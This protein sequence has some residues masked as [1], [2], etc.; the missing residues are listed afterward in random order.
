M[1][2][3]H[4]VGAAIARAAQ[5]LGPLVPGRLV[6]R[7]EY[8]ESR[9][10]RRRRQWRVALFEAKD[11]IELGFGW[12][13]MNRARKAMRL[14]PDHPESHALLGIVHQER[15]HHESALRFLSRAYDLATSSTAYPDN[16]R[17]LVPVAVAELAAA[18]AHSCAALHNE[19]LAADRRDR[20]EEVQEWFEVALHADPFY[21]D[22]I[23]KDPALAPE[24]RQTLQHRL[25]ATSFDWAVQR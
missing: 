21:A 11:L 14:W 2:I 24:L 3:M 23:L 9:D 12:Q 25:D 18:A 1:S 8:R 5:W 4:H 7:H 20:A 6:L 13:A 22:M 16:L 17:G 15:H 10:E 19:S